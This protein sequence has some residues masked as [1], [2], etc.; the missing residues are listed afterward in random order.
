MNNVKLWDMYCGGEL[1][2][3]VAA[4]SAQEAVQEYEEHYGLSAYSMEVEAI[5]RDNA[6]LFDGS[7][8]YHDEDSGE[9]IT[10][11]KVLE[12]CNSLPSLIVWWME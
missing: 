5:E 3:T 2:V 8:A 10:W 1:E 12:Q 11:A 6:C 7:I 9:G 4:A